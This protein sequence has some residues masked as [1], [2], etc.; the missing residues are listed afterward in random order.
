MNPFEVTLN[1][2][3]TDVLSHIDS[4]TDAELARLR[5]CHD[6]EVT[7]RH[8]ARYRETIVAVLEKA[9]KQLSDPKGNVE[10]I[11]S[12]LSSDFSSVRNNFGQKR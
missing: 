11:L 6:A 1:D 10:L 5:M 8:L 3:L 2:S 4:L 9:I 12:E 7:R